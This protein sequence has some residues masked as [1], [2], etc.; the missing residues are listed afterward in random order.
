VT[1]TYLI[2]YAIYPVVS[3]ELDEAEELIVWPPVNEPSEDVDP[4]AEAEAELKNAVA[5][6]RV[7]VV[8]VSNDKAGA[9]CLRSYFAQHTVVSHSLIVLDVGIP[10]HLTDPFQLQPAEDVTCCYHLPFLFV[11]SILDDESVESLHKFCWELV[12]T[13][14]DPFD[15]SDEIYD[16]YETEQLHF[17]AQD[18]DLERVKELIE[19]GYDINAFD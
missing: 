13:N 10:P 18:G 3:S 9:E 11:M 7:F 5:L 4:I 19:E 1:N 8:Q 17:A 14:Y 16:W 2:F 6:A 15:I 12:N